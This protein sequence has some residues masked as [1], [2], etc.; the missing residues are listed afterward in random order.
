M[1]PAARLAAQRPSGAAACTRSHGWLCSSHR[2]RS[3]QCC[4]HQHGSCG[5]FSD[6]SARS[7]RRGSL[8]SASAAYRGSTTLLRSIFAWGNDTQGLYTYVIPLDARFPPALGSHFILFWHAIDRV[9]GSNP[10]RVLEGSSPESHTTPRS[11]SLDSRESA[12]SSAPP[13]SGTPHRLCVSK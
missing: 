9:A 12:G 4:R 10:A 2:G 13:A 8:A 6:V 1:L 11:C 5:R 3:D 7:A